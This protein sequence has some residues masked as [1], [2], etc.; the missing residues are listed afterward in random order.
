[1][2]QMILS[3]VVLRTFGFEGVPFPSTPYSESWVAWCLLILA[4]LL[5]LAVKYR[6][7]LVLGGFRT[8]TSTKE[9]ESIFVE[10]TNGDVRTQLYMSGYVV[11]I[12][13][14]TL[15]ILLFGNTQPFQFLTFIGIVA[16][17]SGYFLVKYLL[18]RFLAFVFFDRNV[19]TICK[20][21]YIQ[22]LDTLSVLLYP[23]AVLYIFLPSQAQ[24][25]VWLLY[26]LCAVFF[27]TVFIVKV[28]QFFFHNLLGL[29]YILLYL[30]GL[31]IIPF[32]GLIWVIQKIL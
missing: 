28:F 12:L 4:A 9:R 19:F 17:V 16:A 22:L 25:F 32:W 27:V 30:C 31:E 11:G 21:H 13:A 5:V 20:R 15:H 18:N 2:I 10:S 1:M 3:S 14:L 7:Q 29:F 6:P 26:L 24:S 23:V 8:I